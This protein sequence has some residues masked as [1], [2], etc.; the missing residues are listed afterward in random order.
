LSYLVL[1][2]LDR[3]EL[4]W[5]VA[6]ILVIVFS[7]A[8]YGIGSSMKGSQII[9]NQIAVVRSSADGT[10]ASV[11]TYAGIF[12]PT[13]ATYDLTV[14]GDALLSALQADQGQGV[15]VVNYATE[16]GDPAH[17]RGLA[18]SVFGLQAV[19][20]EAVIPYT[21]SLKISWAVTDLA[22]QG[23]ATNAGTKPIEDVA[24]VSGTGGTMLGTLAPG[25]SKSFS[26]TL[27]NLNGTSA[28]Q[29]V[30]GMINFDGSAAQREVL[31]RSQVIDALVGYGGGFPGKGDGARWPGDPAL[32]A[33]GRGPVRAADAAARDRH[34]RPV[35]A[36]QR[37]RRDRR[38][39]IAAAARNGEPW[40]RRGDLPHQP[41]ARGER[42]GA[43]Q[44]DGDRRH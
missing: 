31:V 20:A 3:R 4:A 26:M 8:S 7:G 27:H 12:S 38:A 19:R 11:S 21:P 18:V 23:R 17:L 37:D 5:V 35:P 25:E 9:V 34:A 13:R 36:Q 28:S 22:L 43:K 10:A 6:P 44:G 42:P 33:D 14:R 15:P 40:Q 16:Q 32:R 2:R 30:Y 41:A 24:V 29:M 1:R 39:G